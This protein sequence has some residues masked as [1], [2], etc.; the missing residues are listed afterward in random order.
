VAEAEDAGDPD[1]AAI[2][3]RARGA[4]AAVLIGLVN[5]FN[6]E[7]IVV[8]GGLAQGQGDRLLD[9]ARRAVAEGAFRIPGKRVRI[10]PAALGDDVGL[11]GAQ[12]LLARPL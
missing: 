7:L 10:V 5:V 6:P 1:A 12:P 9:P 3:E 11:L 4:F 2:M 8:G